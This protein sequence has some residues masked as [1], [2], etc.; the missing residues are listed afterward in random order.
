LPVRP[1][2]KG[3]RVDGTQAKKLIEGSSAEHLFIDGKGYDSQTT[4]EQARVRGMSAQIPPR[5]RRKMPR[6]YKKRFVLPQAS[7]CE[8][9]SKTMAWHC[10]HYAERIDSFVA[11]AKIQFPIY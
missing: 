5:K 8:R 6:D 1:I 3:S 4:A 7:G 10:T 2:A 9:F 11:T